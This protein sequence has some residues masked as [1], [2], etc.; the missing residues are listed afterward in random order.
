MPAALMLGVT[1]IVISG[2]GRRDGY[3]ADHRGDNER[4]HDPAGYRTELSDS[5][6]QGSHNN[7]PFL[8]CAL[9]LA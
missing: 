2:E 7:L 3:A 5:R 8:E 1:S 9:S 4:H 6:I